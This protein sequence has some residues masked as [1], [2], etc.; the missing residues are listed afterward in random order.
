M[1]KKNKKYDV[2]NVGDFKRIM[3]ERLNKARKRVVNEDALKD[4][5]PKVQHMETAN[6]IVKVIHAINMDPI[7]KKVMTKR[8]IGPIQTGGECTRLSIA[9]ELGIS[10]KEVEQ[11]EN[12]GLEI[13]DRYLQKVSVGDFVGKFNADKMIEREVKKIQTEMNG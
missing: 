7:I 6:L 8:I 13:L 1:I 10:E 11:I 3:G 5:T 4:N 12:A 2:N 9:L